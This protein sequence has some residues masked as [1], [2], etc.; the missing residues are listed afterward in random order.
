MKGYVE[1]FRA[2]NLQAMT[3]TYVLGMVI[4]IA[5]SLT[6]P[7]ELPRRTVFFG[8]Y[9]DDCNKCGPRI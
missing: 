3:D 7:P 5:D 1:H 2:S 6:Q 4:T 8:P 9:P